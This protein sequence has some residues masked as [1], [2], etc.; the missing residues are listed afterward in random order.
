MHPTST[1]IL[2]AILIIVYLILSIVIFALSIYAFI[3]FIKLAN[4][5]IRALD[6]YIGE[7]E[8]HAKGDYYINSNK[9]ENY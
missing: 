1:T 8:G 9:Y 4:R 6:I 2:S 5:G 3:L 7:K